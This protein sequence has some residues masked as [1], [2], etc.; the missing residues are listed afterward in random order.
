MFDNDIAD[1]GYIMNLTRLWA[2]EPAALKGLFDV[3]GI[4]AR[5]GGLSPERRAVLVVAC[6]ST[7]RDA[8]CSLAWGTKLAGLSDPTAAAAMLQGDDSGLDA[9]ER[10]MA[11]WARK[12]AT[13][14]TATQ[15]SDVAALREAGF[16]DREIFAMT[17]YV[18]MRLAFSTVNN[19]LGARADV[20]L[21]AAAPAAV[22]SAVNFGRPVADH[23]SGRS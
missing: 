22:S 5:F 17:V 20:E 23:P 3:L 11:R 12:V 7:L 18:A 21:A 10:A 1:D 15:A 2:H 19:A 8:Y 9:G 4:A 13:D 6:A 14:P 16:D